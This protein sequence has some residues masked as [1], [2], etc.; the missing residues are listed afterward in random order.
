MQ[1]NSTDNSRERDA[2]LAPEDLLNR[3]IEVHGFG[4]GLV[5]A[6]NKKPLF[7]DSLHTV[8]FDEGSEILRKRRPQYEK[9]IV[10]DSSDSARSDDAGNYDRAELQ[11]AFTRASGRVSSIRSKLTTE[12]L[13]ALYALYKQATQGDAPEAVFDADEKQAES[14]QHVSGERMIA[15]DQV[16]GADFVWDLRSNKLLRRP[17]GAAEE[18]HML[19]GHEACAWHRQ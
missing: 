2:E 11:R 7:S 5:V 19:H 12:Q 16:E 1:S 14:L 4:R 3:R 8:E 15:V 9:Q 10:E 6:F 18:A 13:L 17:R